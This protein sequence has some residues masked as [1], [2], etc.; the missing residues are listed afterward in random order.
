MSHFAP[1][2][3]QGARLDKG[4]CPQCDLDYDPHSLHSVI[5][6][7]MIIIITCILSWESLL[8]RSAWQ[9]DTT[10]VIE[11]PDPES[12]LAGKQPLGRFGG[13]QVHCLT[14]KFGLFGTG[15][16]REKLY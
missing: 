12:H 4:I 9:A 1:P 5:L 16:S 14:G 6:Y 7:F 11:H 2:A 8:K 10:C 3:D 15:R 13:L